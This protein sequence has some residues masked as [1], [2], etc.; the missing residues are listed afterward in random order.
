MSSAAT[1]RLPMDYNCFIVKRSV[2][3]ITKIFYKLWHDDVMSKV[4]SRLFEMPCLVCFLLRDDNCLP[5]VLHYPI[6]CDLG[7]DYTLT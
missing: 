2:N 6:T 4:V 5:T 3:P 1:F 7:G